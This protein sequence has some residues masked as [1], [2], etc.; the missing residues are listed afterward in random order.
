MTN[1]ATNVGK[2]TNDG[3]P[4]GATINIASGNTGCDTG[5]FGWTGYSL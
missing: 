5:I 2:D 4:A 1:G 3:N